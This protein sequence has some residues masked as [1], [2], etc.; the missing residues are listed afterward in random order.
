[1]LFSLFFP[2][3]S[4]S[5]S[6]ILTGDSEY[7]G[8]S[9]LFPLHPGPRNEFKGPKH[10]LPTLCKAGRPHLAYHRLGRHWYMPPRSV[11]P[12]YRRWCY[13]LEQHAASAEVNAVFLGNNALVTSA[14]RDMRTEEFG[15]RAIH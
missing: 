8:H 4:S 7:S 12:L 14:K 9:N 13:R 1:M 10:H 5:F 6:Q 3:S 2:C 11:V 15:A